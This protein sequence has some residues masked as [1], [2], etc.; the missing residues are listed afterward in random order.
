MTDIP[1][2][3]MVEYEDADEAVRAVYDDIMARRGISFVPNFWKTVAVHPPTLERLWKQLDAV[4]A[5]GRLDTLTKEMIA[6]AVS[7]TNGCEYCTWSHTAA[8]RKLGLDDETL[9]E[10]M[11]VVG[12]FN[13]T[14]SMASG[15]RV[16]P[17]EVFKKRPARAEPGASV[18]RGG[19]RSKWAGK[20]IMARKKENP[21]RPGSH[22]WRAY[23]WLLDRGGRATYEQYREAGNGLNLLR[24]DVNH[25]F[26]AIE[27]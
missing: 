4:M 14:N 26:A 19:R 10:L 1:T 6:I 20:T 18:K 21:R 25:G 7:A 22:G 23:Q 2:V 13:Q 11:S 9:G 15:M 3:R 24:W 5:P 16:P 8:A 27:D 17:D 12:L